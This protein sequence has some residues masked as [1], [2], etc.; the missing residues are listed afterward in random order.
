MGLTGKRG[1]RIAW[2]WAAGFLWW[3]SQAPSLSFDEIFRAHPGG[4]T[5]AS[6]WKRLGEKNRLSKETILD[7]S[8]KRQN[9]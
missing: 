8:L 3:L 4:Y 1:L 2:E 7:I 6:L 5:P 9:I